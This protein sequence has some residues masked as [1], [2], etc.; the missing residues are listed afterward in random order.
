MLN[1]FLKLRVAG[2]T[3]VALALAACASTSPAPA[4]KATAARALP[5]A[6]CVATPT[7]VV[8]APRDCPGNGHTWTQSDIDRTGAQT[9]AGALRLLDPTLTITGH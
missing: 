4:R 8:A 5:T 7:G 1:D 9:T 3:L 2:A 6:N